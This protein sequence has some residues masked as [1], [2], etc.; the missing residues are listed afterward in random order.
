MVHHRHETATALLPATQA[1]E[2]QG[3]FHRAIISLIFLC[4]GYCEAGCPAGA[5]GDAMASCPD[6][7]LYRTY[8]LARV[9]YVALTLRGAAKL[10]END[11]Q[12]SSV[13]ELRIGLYWSTSFSHAKKL[14]VIR[15]VR[16]AYVFTHDI[17]G[18]TRCFTTRTQPEVC[19]TGL[20]TR[21]SGHMVLKIPSTDN[22]ETRE[23]G[24]TK[25]PN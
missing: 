1:P 14:R 10:N 17:Q 5:V 16:T 15:Y 24:P 22:L 2:N 3:L 11:F 6:A 23:K 4:I 25:T 19:K 21:K 7:L 12:S 8:L 18:L 20:K 9:L 13:R